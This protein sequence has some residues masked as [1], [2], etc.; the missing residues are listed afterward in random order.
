MNRVEKGIKETYD[1]KPYVGWF[2]VLAGS[3][4]EGGR[5][6][7]GKRPHPTKRDNE[8]IPII[9]EGEIIHSKSNLLGLNPRNERWERKFEK[10]DPPPSQQ[11]STPV[12]AAK[13]EP[14][15]A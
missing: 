9:L 2:R 5:T 15:P 10:V 6:Y 14:V 12:R 4:T 1:K 3:H 13:K 8:G 11:E 7:L